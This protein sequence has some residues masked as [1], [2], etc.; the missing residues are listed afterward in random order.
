MKRVIKGKRYDTDKATLIGEHVAGEPGQEGYT[1]ESLYKKRGGEYFVRVQGPY[2]LDAI[3]P[4]THK[5]AEVWVKDNKGMAL[6]YEEFKAQ[7]IKTI[8]VSI[9]LD[10]K[11]KLDIIANTMGLSR[12]KVIEDLIRVDYAKM[13]P[14]D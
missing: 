3:V 14:G 12:N 9:S 5:E 13:F 4:L 6:Y 8:N 2:T 7:G 1:R 11:R 10:V